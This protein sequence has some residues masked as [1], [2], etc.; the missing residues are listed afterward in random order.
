MSALVVPGALW[1][2]LLPQAVVS[3]RVA[4]AAAASAARRRLIMMSPLPVGGSVVAE[5]V[6]A[7]LIR[8]PV[9]FRSGRRRVPSPGEYALRGAGR[10][11]AP[12]NFLRAQKPCPV[13]QLP[14]CTRIASAGQRR[15]AS[16]AR[17]RI[18]AGSGMLADC[19]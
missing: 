8:S 4:T 13:R 10:S 9:P 5:V 15:T 6:T 1:V 18:R 3:A 16:W 7:L 17:R 19:G 14:L 11:M 12:Q 2:P